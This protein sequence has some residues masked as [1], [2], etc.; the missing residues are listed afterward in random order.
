MGNARPIRHS[1]S[2]IRHSPS[3]IRHPP[4]ATEVPPMMNSFRRFFSH[5]TVALGLSALL[6]GCAAN[7]ACVPALVVPGD[8]AVLPQQLPDEKFALNWTFEWKACPE[9]TK[10]HLFVI[11]PT[12]SNPIVNE[13]SLTSAT[14]QFQRSHGQISKSKAQGWTW[15]VRAYADGQWGQW[16]EVRKFNVTPAN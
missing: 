12:A 7:V 11:G 15:K 5:A 1:P 14:Y 3:A 4:S 2:A 6:A 8:N 10:Y 13:D 16:S 9:A